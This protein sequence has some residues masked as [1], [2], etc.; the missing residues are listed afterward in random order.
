MVA[1]QSTIDTT[2][3]LTKI[4][5]ERDITY[6][7]KQCISG[8]AFENTAGTAFMQEKYCILVFFF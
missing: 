4:L 3:I 8:F 6:I 5:Y 1:K 7:L 2:V